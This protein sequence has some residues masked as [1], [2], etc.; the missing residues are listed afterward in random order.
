MAVAAVAAV[1][2]ATAGAGLGAC[3]AAG[4]VAGA[5]TGAVAGGVISYQETGS[6]QWEWVVGGAVAGAAIGAITGWTVGSMAVTPKP[7]YGDVFG[8]YGTYVKNPNIKVDWSKVTTHGAQ[9]M[10]ERNMTNTLVEKV[11]SS[12]KAFSQNA[13]SKYLFLSKDGA[14]VLSSSGEL[15]TTYS[16]AQFGDEIIA[17]SKLL[18]VL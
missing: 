5:V 2:V 15:I 17:L 11:V 13:G 6:V 8:K 16:S 14:V 9:R 1:V 4:A 10:Q 12:G 18:G 7:K 3:I